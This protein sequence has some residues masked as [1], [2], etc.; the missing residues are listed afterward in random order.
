M[1][2]ETLPK[3]FDRRILKIIA[4]TVMFIGHFVL[5][6]FKELHCFG[7]PAP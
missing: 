6:T 2:T 3:P 5:Y 1:R 7:L 4:V